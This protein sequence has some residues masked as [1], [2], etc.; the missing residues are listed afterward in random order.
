MAS[1]TLQLRNQVK[2]A[3]RERRERDQAAAILAASQQL[4]H[5]LYD[6]LYADP[7]WRFEPYSRVTGMDRA[8][9]NHYVTMDLAAIKALKVPAAKDCALLLWSTAPMLLQAVA[10]MAAWG[11]QYRSKCVWVKP[12]IGTGYWWRNQHETLLLGVKGKMRA[13][14][15]GMRFPSV[16]YAPRHRHSEKPVAFAE[17][18]EAM[19][20]N[21][22]KLEMFARGAARAGWDAWGAEAEQVGLDSARSDYAGPATLEQR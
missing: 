13:P 18:I 16:I 12:S 17:M 22:T 7:P 3:R 20:P 1:A 5:R 21:I 11:F 9:D 10:V 15:P 4:G 14:A 19:F 2:H 8:A 6:V